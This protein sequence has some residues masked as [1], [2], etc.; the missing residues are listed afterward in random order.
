MGLFVKINGAGLLK[1]CFFVCIHVS[2][3]KMGAESGGERQ[4]LGRQRPKAIYIRAY[5]GS[6]AS[7]QN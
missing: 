3:Q 6:A 7:M 4:G 1:I 2:V 5:N